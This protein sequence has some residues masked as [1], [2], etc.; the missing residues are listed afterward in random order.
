MEPRRGDGPQIEAD[1]HPAVRW[2]DQHR[3]SRL[4]EQERRSQA[5]RDQT[6]K[7]AIAFLCAFNRGERIA[8]PEFE[9]CTRLRGP[10]SE[11]RPLAG[12]A[13]EDLDLGSFAGLREAKRRGLLPERFQQ[14]REEYDR[15]VAAFRAENY[16]ALRSAERRGSVAPRRHDCGRREHRPGQRRTSRATRAGPDSE[17]PEPAGGREHGLRHVDPFGAGAAL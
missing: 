7:D 1:D 6:N 10:A 9:P 11:D 8:S 12:V 13:D 5:L 15:E 3:E 4:R 14:S 17:D 2:L 16:A